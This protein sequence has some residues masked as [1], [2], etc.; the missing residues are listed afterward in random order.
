M[1]KL[2]G[3]SFVASQGEKHQYSVKLSRFVVE[4]PVDG[5]TAISLVLNDIAEY[6][7]EAE[8]GTIERGKVITANGRSE[9]GLFVNLSATEGAAVTA[10]C[11]E[12]ATDVTVSVGR[13]SKALR[14]FMWVML[15]VAVVIG[16]FIARQFFPTDW[17]PMLKLA[18][19]LLLGAG[20]AIAV[21]IPVSRTQLLAG[22]R[23]GDLAEKL[24]G[25]L[26]EWIE[27]GRR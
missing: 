12:L 24:N 11:Q 1:S 7:D 13:S 16:L 17:E 2:L 8:L 27:V 6:I 14:Y 18:L 4:A 22:R 5:L 9:A 10:S 20:I 26:K 23:S 15:G 3:T 21:A 25:L 19:G